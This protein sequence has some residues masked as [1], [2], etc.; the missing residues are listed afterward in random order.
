[1]FP[2][3]AS[4]R[5]TFFGCCNVNHEA[6]SEL[7]VRRWCTAQLNLV[8][9]N[10]NV[11]N[12][13]KYTRVEMDFLHSVAQVAPLTER[14]CAE[15]LDN[16]DELRTLR[17]EFIFPESPGQ[18]GSQ[19]LYLCGNSLGLQPKRTRNYIL[20]QLDKWG[21]E[22]VEGHFTE[23]T[24]WLT[25]DDIIVESTARLVGAKNAEVVMM[26][27][28]TA[29]LHFMMVSFYRPTS[30]RYKILIEKKSFPSDVH[31][32]VS[33][34]LHHN[35]DPNSALLEIAPREGEATLRVEDIE[36]LIAQEGD[37]IALVLFS[38]VQYYT[39]QFFPLDRIAAAAKAKGCMVGFDLAHAVGNVP[40]RLHDWGCDF[41]C[42]C[43]YKYMNCGPGSIG[44]CFVHERHHQKPNDRPK[45]SASSLNV[46]KFHQDVIEP[47]RFSGWWGHRLDVSEQPHN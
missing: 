44:G 17:E 16:E 25:I 26:N 39:G 36:A 41:A 8:T 7:K 32:V 46:E 43:S 31:A 23:P 38:G 42:W 20:N 30:T 9:R 6:S 45:A 3:P 2:I 11:K 21:R 22:G 24:P 4:R 29:N 12:Y 19:S 15:R 34:I 47:P 1:M 40:L 28:L 37:S 13:L 27:S 5:T 14:A 33:Q 35:L 18:P 10:F